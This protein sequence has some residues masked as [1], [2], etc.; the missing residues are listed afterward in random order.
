MGCAPSGDIPGL[1][2]KNECS[3]NYYNISLGRT[4]AFPYEERF[5]QSTLVHPGK[6]M[7][8]CNTQ[9]CCSKY[10]VFNVINVMISTCAYYADV[11]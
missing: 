10:S 7:V 4:A 3:G 11:I 5:F 1:A 9:K 6:N 2:G 8:V